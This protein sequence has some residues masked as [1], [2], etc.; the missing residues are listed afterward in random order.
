MLLHG[1]LSIVFGL[2]GNTVNMAR[3]LAIVA[4]LSLYACSASARTVYKM[5]FEWKFKL[6]TDFPHCTASSFPIDMSNVRCFGLSQQSA[7]SADKCQDAC[8]GDPNCET[9]QW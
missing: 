7:D 9:W 1:P 2:S 3:I 6:K 8:C 5:D 4:W